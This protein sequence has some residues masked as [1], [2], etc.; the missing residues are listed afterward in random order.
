MIK[1]AICYFSGSGNSFDISLELCKHIDVESIF[2][3]PNL[4]K[5]KLEKYDEIIIVSPVYK[6]NIPVAC[7]V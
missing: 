7:F 4:D 1:T 3:L 6:F 5:K 2:Y